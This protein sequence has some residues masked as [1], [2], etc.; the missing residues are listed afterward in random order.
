M[1]P[2]QKVEFVVYIQCSC[3]SCVCSSI[4]SPT[5]KL[6]FVGPENINLPSWISDRT[7]KDRG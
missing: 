6:V 5:I 7:F 1:K 4:R 3:D 2:R